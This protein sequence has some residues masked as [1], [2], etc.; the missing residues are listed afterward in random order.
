MPTG[1][2]SCLPWQ[3]YSALPSLRGRE[4]G[5]W[6]PTRHARPVLGRGRLWVLHKAAWVDWARR[7]P[8]SLFRLSGLFLLRLAE[9]RFSGLLFQEPPRI[10]RWLPLVPLPE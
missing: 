2:A 5:S 1:S 6:T 7:N 3:V 4:A 10:T 8:R 9:R